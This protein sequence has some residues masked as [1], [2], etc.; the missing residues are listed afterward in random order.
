MLPTLA[1]GRQASAVRGA[2]A[3]SFRKVAGVSIVAAFRRR[4]F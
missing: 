2:E 1:V 4:H 3:G